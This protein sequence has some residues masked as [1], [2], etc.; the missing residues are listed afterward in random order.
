MQTRFGFDECL[1]IR[2]GGFSSRKLHVARFASAYRQRYGDIVAYPFVTEVDK[3]LA[4]F[5][6]NEL[7]KYKNRFKVVETIKEGVTIYPAA[8]HAKAPVIASTKDSGKTYSWSPHVCDMADVNQAANKDWSLKTLNGEKVDV[9]KPP[10][11]K[12]ARGKLS[13]FG[14][15]N[16]LSGS[17]ALV[18]DSV[19]MGEIVSTKMAGD[20]ALMEL[21]YN[22]AKAL[23]SVD[24]FHVHG[25]ELELLSRGTVVATFRS[26][27]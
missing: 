19:T 18:D 5:P 9:E 22:C 27:D 24:G 13:I 11:I 14:G 3:V 16:R 23:A 12:F 1:L 15:I 20:P 10:A 4:E 26:E 6:L 2:S 25:N 17:Y 8:A 7:G 21:E